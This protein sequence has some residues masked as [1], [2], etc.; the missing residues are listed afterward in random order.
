MLL[1]E[2]STSRVLQLQNEFHLQLNSCFGAM[3]E[4]CNPKPWQKEVDHH[5]EKPMLQLR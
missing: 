2:V 4:E 5:L 1:R 3:D